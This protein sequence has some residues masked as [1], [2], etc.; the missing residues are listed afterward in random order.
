[1]LARSVK[2]RGCK[3]H[4]FLKI[5]RQLKDFSIAELIDYL[6]AFALA[7]AIN[8]FQKNAQFLWPPS[9]NA[10]PKSGR[11]SS[12]TARRAGSAQYRP[13][14]HRPYRAYLRRAR[15]WIPR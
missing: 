13:G 3:R 1:M 4:T 7:A 12:A 11:H 6:D 15:F 14:C 5:L 8:L 2:Y 9:L 10:F